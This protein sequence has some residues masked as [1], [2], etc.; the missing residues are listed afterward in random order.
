MTKTLSLYD[1]Q[2]FYEKNYTYAKLMPLLPVCIRLDGKNFSK[3]TKKFNKPFDQLFSTA[4][5][6]LTYFLVEETGA[7]IGYTQS[8][9]ISLILYSN[10]IKSQ[11]YLDGKRDK[12]NSI[13]GSKA[14]VRLNKIF[15]KN[16]EAEPVFDCRCWNVPNKTEAANNLLSR[17]RDATKNSISMAAYSVYS[18]KELLN[19]NSDEKQEMLMKKGINW[20]SYPTCSKRGI[21]I[22]KQIVFRTFSSL[23]LDN[24]PA[25]HAARINPD[26]KIMRTQFSVVDMPCFGKVTNREAVIFDGAKPLVEKK[27][28]RDLL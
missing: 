25:K 17:E 10:N 5:K 27:L 18:H 12:I 2:K 20:N 8:D 16:S 7:T 26:L 3:F 24:L 9:E 6:E 13:L 22:Q 14:S 23:E 11:L 1:R 19:K 21:Y 15:K 28:N 4:M